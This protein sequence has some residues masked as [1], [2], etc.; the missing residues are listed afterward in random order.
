MATQHS[1]ITAHS[2]TSTA[3]ASRIMHLR[4]QKV[5][6]DVDLADL[7]GVQ[8]KVLVQAVKRNPAR[9]PNDFMFQLDSS[10]WASLRS[11]NVT[12]NPARGGRRYPPYAFT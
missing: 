5:M 12:S 6:L 7:Y 4:E 1:V 8:T 2:P 10:E 3:L 11:Q 9:F